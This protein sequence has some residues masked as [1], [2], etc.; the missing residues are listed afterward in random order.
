M[1][2]LLMPW[3]TQVVVVPTAKYRYVSDGLY[4][5]GVHMYPR[6]HMPVWG[7]GADWGRGMLGLEVCEGVQACATLR[8]KGGV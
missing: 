6:A 4:G 2:L 5:E 8:V 3:S 7:D 1:F